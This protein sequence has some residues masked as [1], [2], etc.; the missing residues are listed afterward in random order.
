[1]YLNVVIFVG[2]PREL[3]GELMMNRYKAF[4]SMLV[5]SL[6]G[7]HA[8]EGVGKSSR[9][10]IATQDLFKQ[11]YLKICSGL[12]EIPQQD[13]SLFCDCMLKKYLSA[14]HTDKGTLE[15]VEMVYNESLG[16]QGF[17]DYQSLVFEFDASAAEDCL[18][19]AS[20]IY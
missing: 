20:A 10:N 2:P 17:T 19:Q 3:K 7:T 12:E 15:I 6:L 4:F 9:N 5:F 8:S 1:M 14:G 18:E 11:S 13:R 16:S